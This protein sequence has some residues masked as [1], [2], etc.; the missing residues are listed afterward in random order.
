LLV[1]AE[2]GGFTVSHAN[3]NAGIPLAALPLTA[4]YTQDTHIKEHYL[5]IKFNTA[6]N[7]LT[8]LSWKRS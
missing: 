7:F 4:V 8:M 6:E 2:G 1:R 3:L 5:I